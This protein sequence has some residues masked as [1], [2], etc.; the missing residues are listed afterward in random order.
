ME[1]LFPSFDDSKESSTEFSRRVFVKGLGFVT[2]GLILGAVGGC[3]LDKLLEAIANRPTRRWLRTGSPE[4]DADIAT[5]KQGVTL[6][7]GLP[8]ADPRCWDKQAAIHGVAR[9]CFNFCQHSTISGFA[10][11]F[12]D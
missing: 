9:C 12:F 1:E 4:V 6:M 3:D 10:D 7:K 8:A 11:H 2:V 5:Y